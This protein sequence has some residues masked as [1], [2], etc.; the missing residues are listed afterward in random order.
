MRIMFLDD[1]R[2]HMQKSSWKADFLLLAKVIPL[3]NL[4]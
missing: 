4:G 1:V 3:A 2:H